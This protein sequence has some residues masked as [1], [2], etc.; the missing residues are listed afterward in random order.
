MKTTVSKFGTYQGQD[1]ELY[2]IKNN[3]GVEI[4]ISSFGATIT[5]VNVPNDKGGI[6]NLA[7]GFDQFENYF[8]KVYTDNAPYFG[9]TVGRYCS[10]IKN[11]KFSLNGKEYPLAVNC[12]ENNLHGGVVGFDKKVWAAKVINTDTITG[13]TMSLISKDL[14]EGFPG[15]V[16]VAVTFTLND[17][18]EL[19]INY[20]ATPDQDTPLA[21]TNHTYFN[22]N[23]FTTS[24]EGHN[25]KIKASNKLA[26]DDTGA[27]PGEVV[28]LN[29]EDDDLRTSKI[30]KHVHT[31]MNDGFEHYYIFDKEAF[32]LEK[33]AEIS[34]NV[35]S[36][37]LEVSTTEPGMLFYTGKYTSDEIQ[38]ENGQKFGK[39]KGFCCETHRFPNGP[40]IKNSPKSI[41]K[42]GEEFKST[43]I[44][45]FSW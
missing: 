7:C 20:T 34:S 41:T 5:T 8:S 1:I 35:T 29:G 43:T 16:N 18:N 23:G 26:M 30:I 13:V 6:E 39:Y 17:N 11:S 45:K 37:K 3:N 32:Q 14:E 42:A 38:R 24:I 40:N 27:A 36:R 33:V 25:V 31:A 28:N 12:G 4:K 21:L 9:G 44:F 19:S 22:L 15:N 10:Q 2:S